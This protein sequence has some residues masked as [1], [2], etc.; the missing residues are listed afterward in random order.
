MDPQA[1]HSRTSHLFVRMGVPAL[2]LAILGSSAF[3]VLRTDDPR[4]NPLPLVRQSTPYTCGVACL[5][6]ILYYY[7]QEWPEDILAR[8]LKSTEAEGTNYHEILRFARSRGL[9]AQEKEGMTIDDLRRACAVGRPIIVAY[10]AW[11]AR[12]DMYANDWEDGHYSIVV[13]VDREKV[14][15]MDPSTL[16]NYAFIPIPEF[17]ARWHDQ[18]NGPDGRPIRLVRFGITLDS[19]TKPSYNPKLFLPVN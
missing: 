12:P 6:S 18:Y 19:G 5:Q 10:Q 14:Y 17:E 11:G 9:T 1:K 3:L 13:G 7:G 2:F 16:G 8:E 15:L 4:L